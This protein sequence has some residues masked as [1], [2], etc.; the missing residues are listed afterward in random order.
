MAPAV[1]I[2]LQ[3]TDMGGSTIKCSKFMRFSGTSGTPKGSNGMLIAKN[4]AKRLAF[5]LPRCVLNWFSE[6]C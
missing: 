2:F 4:I 5:H 1:G 3:C 6:T